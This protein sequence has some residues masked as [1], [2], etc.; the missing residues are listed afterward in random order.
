[1]GRWPTATSGI[2]R[3][4]TGSET[5]HR[6]DRA[7]RRGHRGLPGGSSL[8]R[9]LKEQRG[10]RNVQ[11]LPPLAEA[12]ILT[13]ADGYH[14]QFSRWPTARP[15]PVDGVP[16][17]TW[18]AIDAALHH[19]LRGLPGRSSLSLLLRRR[20]GLGD[21]RGAQPDTARCQEMARLRAEGLTLAEIGRRFG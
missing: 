4:K 14:T 5:W 6:I 18:Q 11:D 9:L 19:G 8:A 15:G 16:Y 13:W 2:I 10:V 17:L 7:M 12:Q 1:T 20:R 3:G 21:R